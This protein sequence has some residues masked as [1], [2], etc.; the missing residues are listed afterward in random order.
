LGGTKLNVIRVKNASFIKNATPWDCDDTSDVNYAFLVDKKDTVEL[1]NFPGIETTSSEFRKK[2]IETALWLDVDPNW[3]AAVISLESNFKPHIQNRFSKATG[4]IQF[5]PATAR[6]FNLTL[7]EIK[8]MDA[9]TQLEKCVK[10]YFA[11]RR[12]RLN[13]LEDTYLHV[14]YPAAIGKDRDAVIGAPGTKVY[15]QNKGFDKNNKG[16]FT[17]K[18]ITGSI[19]SI[20]NSAKS[21]PPIAVYKINGS[22]VQEI[23]SSISSTQQTSTPSQSTE[24]PASGSDSDFQKLIDM[25]MGAFKSLK[26]SDENNVC[27]LVRQGILEKELLKEKI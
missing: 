21:K 18:D 23:S 19:S 14:F 11:S 26:A 3:L 7:D 15:E 20:Y 27:K 5:M 1:Y 2:L 8:N 6:Q 25:F 16:Y 17:K 9:I 24:V 4:L 13:S 10:P 22:N 12:G